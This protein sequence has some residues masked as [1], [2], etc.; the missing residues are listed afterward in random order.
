MDPKTFS[1]LI[2]TQTERYAKLLPAHIPAEK[3][4]T[5]AKTFYV[6]SLAKDKNNKLANASEKSIMVALEKAAKDG[7]LMDGNEAC[8]MTFGSEAQY[9]PMVWGLMK[10]IQNSGCVSKVSVYVVWSNEL[11]EL[12]IINGDEQMKHKPMV[13]APEKE[14]GE[15]VGV[16]AAAKLK[17]GNVLFKYLSKEKVV[18]LRAKS[19]NP[20]LWDQEADEF[21]SKSAL[22]QISKFLPKN[23]EEMKAVTSHLDDEIIGDND[24]VI[25]QET[26]EVLTAAPKQMTDEQFDKAYDAETEK[27][28]KAAEKK[29]APVKEKSLEEDLR[30]QAESMRDRASLRSWFETDLTLAEQKIVKVWIAEILDKL[31]KQTAAAAAPKATQSAPTS[32]TKNTSKKLAAV[33]EEDDLEPAEEGDAF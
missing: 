10:L 24:E 32:A 7:L 23:S 4:V 30:E 19:K 21:W 1:K 27:A 6:D 17:D 2:D 5:S 15:R 13:F 9:S 12:E 18:K 11:F 25:D 3:F 16:Y 31:P 20:K 33:V 22:R 28:V 8:W 29:S 26:G 14:K